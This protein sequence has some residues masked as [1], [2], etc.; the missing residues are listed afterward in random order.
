MHIDDHSQNTEE[1]PRGAD[2]EAPFGAGGVQQSGP[3]PPLNGYQPLNQ[4][5]RSMEGSDMGRQRRPDPQTTN[6]QSM[7]P[8]ETQ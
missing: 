4:E 7:K 5:R 2:G 8:T 6:P 3:A 1:A